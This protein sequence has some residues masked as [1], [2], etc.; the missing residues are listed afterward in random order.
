VFGWNPATAHHWGGLVVGEHD[1]PLAVATLALPTIEQSKLL[2]LMRR[3]GRSHHPTG[4]LT[5]PP[6]AI[7]ADVE[8]LERTVTGKLREA[9]VRAVRPAQTVQ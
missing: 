4:T 1:K 8:Y 7:E 5:V 9:V 3:Y 2:R 6:E